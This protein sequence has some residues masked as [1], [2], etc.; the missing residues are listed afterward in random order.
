MIGETKSSLTKQR[1]NKD[2]KTDQMGQ[3]KLGGK[4]DQ[5]KSDKTGEETDQK[6]GKIDKPKRVRQNRDGKKEQK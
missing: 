2:Q 6:T 5:K 4:K 1:G 3:T